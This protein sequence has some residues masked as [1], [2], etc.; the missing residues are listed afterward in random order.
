M[1]TELKGNWFD[2]S[3][4]F[5]F[6]IIQFLPPPPRNW[7]SHRRRLHGSLLRIRCW[8]HLWKLLQQRRLWHFH[9][10]GRAG[11]TNIDGFR[12]FFWVFFW[13]FI[14]ELSR[15]YRGFIKDLSRVY[16]VV[17]RGFIGGLLRFYR[18]LI[19]TLPPL[20]PS[21]LRCCRSDR[22]GLCFVVINPRVLSADRVDLS[23]FLF[24]LF[25][26]FTPPPSSQVC[27]T[28]AVECP[29]CESES[30]SFVHSTLGGCTNVLLGLHF[31]SKKDWISR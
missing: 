22:P 5:C 23:F 14:E 21:F 13:E 7:S 10:P 2:N 6:K 27:M 9:S 30:S 12:G 19:L 20:L 25:S 15:V 4:V 18:R 28:D 26:N 29:T 17:Y 1:C 3:G 16:R 31:G 24:H 8:R 11:W